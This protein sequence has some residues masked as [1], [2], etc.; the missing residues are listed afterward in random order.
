ML[1]PALPSLAP[2][3]AVDPCWRHV[4]VRG[5][6]S[7]PQLATHVHCRNC[8]VYGQAAVALLDTLAAGAQAVTDVT[9]MTGVAESSGRADAA[10][11]AA[12]RLGR[13][14]DDA[15]GPTLAC[16]LFRVGREWLALPATALG[17]I[18]TPCPVHSLPHQRH[19]AVLGLAG[20][21]GQLLVCISLAALLGEQTARDD[22][23]VQGARVLILGQG[24]SAIALPVDEVAGVERVAQDSLQA[25]PTT[26]SRAAL[27]YLQGLLH[28]QGR[29]V[30]LL[31]PERLRQALLES[32]A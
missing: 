29:S 25:L 7:C 6:G 24:R 9:D 4:G 1:E 18:T 17:E 23:P 30:G 28:C 26:L 27:P 16:L 5:D 31:D 20:V 22:T 8:P 2:A 32:L 19:A 13:A 21:R 14:A 3:Q 10:D 12:H 11:A 15:Q